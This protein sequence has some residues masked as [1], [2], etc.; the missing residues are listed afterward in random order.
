MTTT[1]DITKDLTYLN[2]VYALG[3]IVRYHAIV[4]GH[5][6]DTYCVII[7]ND[8]YEKEYIFQRVNDFV[9]KKPYIIMRNLSKIRHY[10]T[11]NGKTSGCSIQGFLETPEGEN[12]VN[13][14]DGAFWRVSQF[15][16]HSITYET[17]ESAEILRKTGIAFGSFQ[18]QLSGM[19]TST[20]EETIPDFHNTPKRLRDLEKAIEADRVHRA[21]E[22][23]EEIAFY[24][25][26]AKEMSKLEEMRQAGE[27]P[28]R[29][30]HN[31]TKSNNILFDRDS[32]D[33]IAIID[34]DTVMPGL[35]MHDF[36]D[37]IRFA[38]STATE[39]EKD[40]SKVAL[41]LPYFEAFTE[42]FVGTAGSILTPAE[43]ANMALGALVMTFECGSRFLADYLDGDRYFHTHYDGQNL[44]RTRTQK[45]L[46]QDMMKHYDQM[47]SI[48]DRY[49]RR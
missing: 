38:A 33:P 24:R 39:D 49:A 21:A 10:L 19:D 43:C 41:N 45:K 3:K 48:V 34:L 11:A 31:D 36:G 14:A 28:T 27:L 8:G 46:C 7:E 22:V 2:E 42:G 16:D 30:T 4:N 6:N 20:L 44:N 32:G 9:F 25:Q 1:Y 12:Y 18:V 17:I 15:V 23:T 35:S 37:T 29:V 5:I 26:H 47:C 13:T 40:L